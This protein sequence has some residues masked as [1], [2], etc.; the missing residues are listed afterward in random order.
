MLSMQGVV[1]DYRDIIYI[2]F[3]MI[4]SLIQL[5]AIYLT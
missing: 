2:F 3:D 5:K 4:I 1:L